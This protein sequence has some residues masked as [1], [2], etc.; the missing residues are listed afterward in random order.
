MDL[1]KLGVA[2]LVIARL[3]VAYVSA[4]LNPC[5]KW[6]LA[7]ALDRFL[8]SLTLRLKKRHRTQ[9][10]S[11]FLNSVAHYQHHYWT[12]HD[13][14]Y[15]RKQ[16]PELFKRTNPIDARNLSVSDDPISYGMRSFDRIVGETMKHCAPE[17]ILILTGLSQ[18]PF[19]GYADGRGFYL[20]RPY[21]HSKLFDALNIKRQRVVP[22]M[23]RDAMLHFNDPAGCRQAMVRLEG[24]TVNNQKLFQVDLQPNDRL[25]VKVDFTFQCQKGDLIVTADGLVP[26]LLFADY[27]QLITFKTGHHAPE[28]IAL[29]PNALLDKKTYQEPIPLEHL[30]ALLFKCMSLQ[31]TRHYVGG[32]DE[33][34][35]SV[36][37]WDTNSLVTCSGETVRTASHL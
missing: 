15:W 30:P 27:F 6:K 22:L 8:F 19:E 10:T 18:V 2:P 4:R 23:S 5:N 12:R 33:P 21:D 26:S 29:V 3:G 28:G 25:F 17:S 37:E 1:F 34:G 7:A 32:M 9:Y 31:R 35:A 11:V 36:P 14:E 13:T 24:I 16:Y 20:Y